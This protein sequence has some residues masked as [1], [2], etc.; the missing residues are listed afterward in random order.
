MA[1]LARELSAQGHKIISLSLGEP[2]FDTP[3][4]IKDA[5]KKALDDGFTK[6]T[7]V[8]GFLDLRQ[9]I[10]DKFERDNGLSYSTDQIVV[11]C[12][13]KHS[14][15]NI[16]LAMINPGDEV[17]ILAPY[18]TSYSDIVK[19]G[20]GVP[21]IIAADVAQDYKVTAAQIE[22]AITPKTKMLWFS[23]PCNPTGSVFSSA[24]LEA[25]ANVIA[26]HEGIFIVSDEIYEYINYTEEGHISIASFPQ[27]KDRTITVNGF[28]KGFAMTGWRLGYIGAP[29][30]IAKACEKV[31]GQVTS[32]VTSF[33]QKAAVT[34]L[35]SPLDE[36][37][38]MC[39]AFRTR[40]ALVMEL[41]SDIEGFKINHPEGAFYI[42]PDISY[43]FNKSYGEYSIQN[44]DDFCMFLLGEAKV[45]CVEGGA[46]GAPNC[47]RLSYA[48]SEEN[49][50][51][52]IRRIKEAVAKLS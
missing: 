15:A 39:D 4:F 42:F 45:A 16:V 47:F 35:N 40:R 3:Q 31:Q 13:A 49:I 38:K 17:I 20:E 2:D 11:S 8:P 50:R 46:F 29:L 30:W 26:A 10:S 19:L 1:R 32:G 48:A 9:A 12:G 44:A 14:L 33:A 23:S 7:P 28:A 36:T 21:V 5:A 43:Y 52:A 51:E 34:A 18:W 6:Y 25:I 24:E 22:A 37:H 41:M 27:V